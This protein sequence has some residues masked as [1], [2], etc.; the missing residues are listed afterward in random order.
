[1]VHKRGGLLLYIVLKSE[2]MYQG[3]KIYIFELQMCHLKFTNSIQFYVLF[4][5]Y[6]YQNIC[7]VF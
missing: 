5:E 3:M 2:L 4:K 7:T 1:M 6:S